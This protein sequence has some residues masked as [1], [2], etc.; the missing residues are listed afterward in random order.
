[1]AGKV[2]K[3]KPS[4]FEIGGYLIPDRERMSYV[5]RLESCVFIQIP[6]FLTIQTNLHSNSSMH[7]FYIVHQLE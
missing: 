1:M 7:H 2:V 6:N 5:L 3:R 4:K